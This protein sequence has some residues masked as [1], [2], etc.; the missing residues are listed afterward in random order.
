MLLTSARA[1]PHAE[2]NAW[3]DYGIIL[4]VANIHPFDSDR[5]WPIE[6]GEVLVAY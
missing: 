6:F 2:L 5:D 3:S 1:I 4:V